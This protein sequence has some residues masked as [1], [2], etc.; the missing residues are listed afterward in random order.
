M[1]RLKQKQLSLERSQ[2]TD[3]PILNET[4]NLSVLELKPNWDL[5]LPGSKESLAS[6]DKSDLKVRKGRPPL[7]KS[8]VKFGLRTSENKENSNLE[9][10]DD[11][12]IL[13]GR[14]GRPPLKNLRNKSGLTTPE[15]NSNDGKEAKTTVPNDLPEK[16]LV[17]RYKNGKPI[18]PTP[19]GR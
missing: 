15:N 8:G 7:K 5:K 16:P 14:R 9:T 10:H 3:H 6:K 19:T 13:K 4:T 18:R 2:Q 12:S 17:L 1:D 11:K